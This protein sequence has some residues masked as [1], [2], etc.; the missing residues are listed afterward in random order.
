M[1]LVTGI[2]GIALL[3]AFLGTMVWWIR[4]WP[5]TI[6]VLAVFGMLVHDFVQ[7]LRSANGTGS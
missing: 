1:T 5:F 4:E 2:V 7:T 3:A 6:I